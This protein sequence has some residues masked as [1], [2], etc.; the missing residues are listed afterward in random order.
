MTKP[1]ATRAQRVRSKMVNHKPIP[2]AVC[3]RYIGYLA[4]VPVILDAKKRIIEFVH[5]GCCVPE[6]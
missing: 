6:K 4:G 2:C 3:G 5:P 1:A